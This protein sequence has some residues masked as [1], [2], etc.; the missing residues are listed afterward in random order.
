MTFNQG[1]LSLQPDDSHGGLL[2]EVFCS[3]AC[4]QGQ[5]QVQGSLRKRET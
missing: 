1:S 2:K 4:F 5:R 3:K